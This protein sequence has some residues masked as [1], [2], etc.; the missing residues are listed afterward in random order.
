MVFS[1]TGLAVGF[2]VTDVTD[3]ADKEHICDANVGDVLHSIG[4]QGI[5]MVS[6]INQIIRYN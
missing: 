3:D 4:I 2:N 6:T 5:I 1:D